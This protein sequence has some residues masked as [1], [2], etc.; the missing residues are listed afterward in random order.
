MKG[1][2]GFNVFNCTVCC[3]ESLCPSLENLPFPSRHILSPKQS[4]AGRVWSDA[5]WETSTPVIGRRYDPPPDFLR[6]ASTLYWGASEKIRSEWATTLR[7]WVLCAVHTEIIQ[8]IANFGLLPWC[9]RGRRT[10]E[11][12]KSHKESELSGCPVA[13]R[14]GYVPALPLPRRG[15]L[16]RT[17]NQIL[18]LLAAETAPKNNIRTKAEG[19]GILATRNPMLT[20]SFTGVVKRLLDE[21]N[22]LESSIHDPPRNCL[23]VPLTA[24]VHYWG[25]LHGIWFLKSTRHETHEKAVAV[26]NSGTEGHLNQLVI[27]A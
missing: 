24:S 16:G 10:V 1:N 5:D 27:R 13:R 21:G 3:G 2:A 19:S 25:E 8:G 22:Q 15:V 18:R 23:A 20:S 4:V 12:R 14:R 17:M 7:E 9:D 26:Q 6:R 11:D